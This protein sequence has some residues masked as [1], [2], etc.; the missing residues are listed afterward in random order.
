MRRSKLL[1]ASLLAIVFAYPAAG[2]D[3]H[4]AHQHEGPG[5]KS[6]AQPTDEAVVAAQRP[7]YPLDAC[8]VSGKD[9]GSMGG[10][11]DHVV[12]GRLVL[13][14][15]K[16]CIRTVDKDPAKFVAKVDAA[17]VAA[18][19][20]GYPLTTDAMT[21]EE[22]GTDAIDYVHGTRLIRLANKASVEAFE[23]DPRPTM[24]R[25]DEAL[26]AAQ[27][28]TYPLQECVVS[29]EK[30]GGE[31]GEP[32]DRLHGTRLVRLCCKGCVKQ[33]E[34]DPTSYLAQIDAAAPIEPAS[35][36]SAGCCGGCGADPV[37]AGGSGN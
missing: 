36:P 29:G 9:L 17:V 13:L 34:K 16:G 8:A 23:K 20:P 25:V 26:I 24:Q 33:F 5:D 3:G 15:C 6:V 18:Q 31:M 14:C 28:V 21:G 12:Q 19:K 11:I 7:S 1:D 35:A 10:A 32:V 2:Q 22:L 4:E 30:L 27:R 37:S